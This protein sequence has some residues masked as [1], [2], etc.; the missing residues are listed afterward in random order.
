MRSGHKQPDFKERLRGLILGVGEEVDGAAAVQARLNEDGSS[1]SGN[2]RDCLFLSDNGR[3]FRDVSALSALDSPADGRSFVIWDYDRDGWS[4]LA[5]VNSGAPRLEMYRNLLGKSALGNEPQRGMVALRF[6]GG[7][8]SA[9]PSSSLSSR[10]G[11]GA[12]AVLDLG[13]MKVQRELAAG[14]GLAA[15]NSSTLV[16][17]IGAR[18]EVQSVTVRWPSGRIQTSGSIGEG[19]LV[20]VYEDE[21]QSPN[22]S[23]FQAEAYRRVL[24]KPKPAPP[25][26]PAFVGLEAAKGPTQ[27][28]MFSTMATWCG[29]CR[30][31]VP[32]LQRLR[33]T[34][35]QT[36]LAMFGVAIDPEDSAEKLEAWRAQADPPYL[37][38]K[39]GPAEVETLKEIV[40][41][42]LGHDAV[43]ATLIAD[44]QGRVLA[45]QWG[46]PSVSRIRELL[47]SLPAR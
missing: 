2:E 27:L 46:P 24:A 15:Q 40:I 41:T 29:P 4:D 47:A 12:Q 23:G 28:R 21:R 36:D 19:S 30:K 18:H 31:E 33:A 20:T 44:A 38:V 22:G 14:E 8:R 34:F 35:S 32:Q 6:V 5:V 3:Q 26:Q 16:I 13:D 7:N 25:P 17:G 9:Q 43:P 37:F 10:D 11:Y 42:R 1:F 45:A 39:A